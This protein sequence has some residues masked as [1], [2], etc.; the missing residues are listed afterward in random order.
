MG[1]FKDKIELLEAERDAAWEGLYQLRGAPH[2]LDQLRAE[3]DSARAQRDAAFEQLSLAALDAQDWAVLEAELATQRRYLKEDFQQLRELAQDL[4]QR[5]LAFKQMMESER[6]AL[7]ASHPAVQLDQEIAAKHP[8]LEG[9]Q[10]QLESETR[11]LRLQEAE[12]VEM[13]AAAKEANDREW[14]GL[15]QERVRLARLRELLRLEQ[16]KLAARITGSA[17][18]E[19]V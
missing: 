7:F 11:E 6:Q 18:I 17:R 16:E 5:E 15:A 12:I 10:Q 2:Q 13:R 3:R 19:Q 4:R 8:A 1:A 9:L 14:E